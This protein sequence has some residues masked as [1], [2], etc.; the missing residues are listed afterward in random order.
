LNILW[1]EKQYLTH[2][3]R[4]DLNTL[5]RNLNDK[6]LE[7]ADLANNGRAAGTGVVRHVSINEKFNKHR[8]CEDGVTEPADPNPA[9]WFLHIG[10]TDQVPQTVTSLPQLE[11]PPPF[12]GPNG[13]APGQCEA[14]LNKPDLTAG[15]EF[16]Q[17]MACTVAEARANGERLADYL[18]STMPSGEDPPEEFV[19]EYYGKAFHPKS[20]GH[21]AIAE[22][23]REAATSQ[24]AQHFRRVLLIFKGNNAQWTQLNNLVAQ[25]GTVLHVM[26]KPGIGIKGVAAMLKLT[27]AR[28]LRGATTLVAV[29]GFCI[30][31]DA[32]TTEETFDGESPAYTPH[33]LVPKNETFG[34][35]NKRQTTTSDLELQFGF[36]SPTEYPRHLA[37]LS[38]PPRFHNTLYSMYKGYL[39]NPQAGSDINIYILDAPV[40]R[41]HEQFQGRLQPGYQAYQVADSDVLGPPSGHGTCMASFAG[42]RTLGVTKQGQNIVPVRFIGGYEYEKNPCIRGHG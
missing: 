24:P 33:Y 2:E 20:A 17:Y 36:F 16:A 30:E 9:G 8:F 40:T 15:L 13:L 39:H 6:L 31:K 27:Q 38:N 11:P 12:E 10:G 25:H 22:A 23:V 35:L 34:H 7:A 5:V 29:V 21:H 37:Q 32:Y 42:G 14:L 1:G 18:N 26:E 19:P 4:R 3:K 41:G 28:A